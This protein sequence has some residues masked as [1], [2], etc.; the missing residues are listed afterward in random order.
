VA[1][2]IINKT[3]LKESSLAKVRPAFAGWLGVLSLSALHIVS[4]HQLL[5]ICL[6]IASPRGFLASSFYPSPPSLST[7]T[8]HSQLMR[9]VKIMKMLNHPN[10]VR[11][12]EVIDTEKE[13]FLIMEYASG[14]EV[15]DYLVAHGRMQEKEARVKFR[16]VGGALLPPRLTM[17]RSMHSH[18][19]TSSSLLRAP[20]LSAPCSTATTRRLCTATSR[21]RIFCLTPTWTL[22]WP[23]LVRFHWTPPLSFGSRASLWKAPV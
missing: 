23:I 15:F 8:P 11:L 22:N 20:R 4:L 2:K 5:Y 10:I 16:Q 3:S 1:V 21:P 6:F 14:G 19:T 9:E 12:Y 18:S 17:A 7:R 13:L